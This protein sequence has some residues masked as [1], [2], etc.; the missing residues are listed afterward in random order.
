MFEEVDKF[1]IEE[2]R[3][4]AAD[5]EFAGFGG[6]FGEEPEHMG[7]PGCVL[8]GRMGVTFVIRFLVMESVS[9]G[10]CEW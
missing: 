4:I 1:A 8:H 2:F 6:S 5:E 10:P 7:P 9:S 3:A